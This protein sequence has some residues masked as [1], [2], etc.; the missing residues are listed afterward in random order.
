MGILTWHIGT[1]IFLN[2]ISDKK[3]KA[4]DQ[5]AGDKGNKDTEP[6]NATSL[7]YS[8]VAEQTRKVLLNIWNNQ[9]ATNKDG[10]TASCSREKQ[11]A[12]ILYI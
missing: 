11:L 6:P 7:G 12:N 2:I 1:N 9:E 4:S 8:S 3:A 5:V 10:E